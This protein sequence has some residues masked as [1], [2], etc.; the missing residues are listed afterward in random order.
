MTLRI[1]FMGT[2]EFAVPSLSEILSAGHDV[3]RVYTQPPAR[4]GR[5][6]SL[7]K[8]PVHQ[9]AEIMGLPVETPESFRKPSV[10]DELE[11]LDVDVACV[12][13][14]GQIL[15]VRA[16]SAPRLGCLNLHGSKLPRWRGAA[17]IQRAVLAGDT[18]T[19]AQIMQMGK[20]L[21]TGPILLSEI[22][23]ISNNDTA[24]TLHDRM[25]GIGAGLWPRALA[26]LS[27]GGLTMTEQ[28]GEVTYA[29]KI[30]KSETRINW[31]QT[32]KDVR[33]QIRGFS[34]FP[35]AWCELPTR[36]GV[37]RVKIH[38]AETGE[39]TGIAGTVLDD[40]L[41]IA[42][43]EGAVRLTKLQPAGKGIMTADEYLRGRPCPAGA[44]LT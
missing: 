2:P 29:S 43:R 10:I 3:V 40:E 7:R 36:K 12:V 1:A 19:A 11:A 32:A 6:K 37:E 16:L 17:P 23:P 41:L 44:A 9:F 31:D 33:N 21:D 24:G 20:G 39:G 8:S 27:R 30:E 42:C 26:A 38:M 25:M 13:A 35:G 28:E 15:P 18:E 4:A 14:Y 34:P 22:I 5:G